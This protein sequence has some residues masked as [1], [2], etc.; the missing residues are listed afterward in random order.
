MG[1]KRTTVAE[2]NHFVDLKQAGYTIP[3]IAEETGWSF[4]CVRYWCRRHRDGG[5][6]ALAP[7]DG[8]KE[9]G[10]RMS[11]FLGVVR[12]ACLRIKKEHPGWGADV[13]RPRMAQR[14]DRPEETMP[15]VS[16]IEQYWAQFGDRLYQRHTKRRPAVK[17]EPGP[18]P[19]APHER[20]Q[21]DFKE[22]VPVAGVGKVDVLNIRDEFTPVKIG[23]FVYPAGQCTGR[24]VQA[25][26]RQAFSQ[27]GL[28]DRFQTDQDKRLVNS[29]HDHPFPTLFQL[30]LVGL[31]VAHD[32][33]PSAQ[34][35]GCS[36]R[37]HRTWHGRV[38]L[39]RTFNDLTQLQVVSDEELDWMNR[40]LP[41]RGRDCNGRPPLT[42]YPEAETP[43]RTYT[44]DREVELFSMERVYQYLATQHWWRRVTEVG[45]MSL[46]SQRYG[47]G[48]AYANQDVKVTFDPEHAEFVVEDERQET[49]K[50]LTPKNLTV[51][52][53]TDLPPS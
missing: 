45:Q 21:A 6:A 19:Q 9:R 7:P 5:R 35:N 29:N 28:C 52:D 32:L 51:A 39:G 4:E 43:R 49:I 23:S 38:V 34:A 12:F 24:D 46:G 44:P 25:A 42:A 18:T 50:H 22:W 47:I 14:L 48:R 30:W 17:P 1:Q 27:W 20:W 3:E 2:R 16:T 11:T 31:G 10:G 8:R 13:A 40:K 53:I 37:F 26:L 36:E 15:S 33:A 41:S